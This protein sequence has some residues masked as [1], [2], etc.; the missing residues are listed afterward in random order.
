VELSECAA[1]RGGHVGGDL[2]RREVMAG[3]PWKHADPL[4]SGAQ[5]LVG[6]AV[7]REDRRWRDDAARGEGRDQPGLPGDVGLR[8]AFVDPHEPHAALGLDGEVGVDRS[9]VDHAHGA[10][11]SERELGG[12]LG[13][14]GVR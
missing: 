9:G 5:P 2:V 8:L 7:A 6:P 10:H 14:L 1:E 12:K 4:V 3:A 11:S 13:D